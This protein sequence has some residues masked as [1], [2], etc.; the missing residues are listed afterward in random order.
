MERGLGTLGVKIHPMGDFS[1]FK[2]LLENLG[3]PKHKEKYL[4]ELN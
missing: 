3:V 1:S 4:K 2:T